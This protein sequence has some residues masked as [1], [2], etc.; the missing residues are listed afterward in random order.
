MLAPRALQTR[1]ALLREYSG[2][3]GDYERRWAG[4]IRASVVHTLG[5]L[6]LRPG[7]CV[8]DVGCGSG[9]LLRELASRSP[10]LALA[11]VD[12]VPAMLAQARLALPAQVTLV[13]AWAEQL[14]FAEGQ[15]DAL[16]CSS[17]LHYLPEPRHAL[18]E[19]R[20]VLRPGGQLLLTDWCHDYLSCQLC[21]GYL[22]WRGGA[23][24][25]SYRL[26]DAEL[27][28]QEAGLTVASAERYKISWLWGLMTLLARR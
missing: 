27:L 28:L 18:A 8:L 16:I 12:A 19:M 24:V 2:L 14:P 13:R 6:Q 15:F 23:H 7:G 3:A 20:R 9:A 5:R 21:D 22:R 11:G 10:Q 17:V 4:Y 26:R 25:R 1:N